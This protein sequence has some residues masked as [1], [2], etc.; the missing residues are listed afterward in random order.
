M[1]QILFYLLCLAF[2]AKSLAQSSRWLT[3]VNE[4]QE[5]PVALGGSLMGATIYPG[6]RLLAEYPLKVVERRSGRV[7]A[8]G[9]L[10][11]YRQKR[12][13][14]ALNFSLNTYYQKGFHTNLYALVEYQ[15]RWLNRRGCFFEL[16]PLGLG[17]SYTF[18][19]AP[20]FTTNSQGQVRQIPLAG[21]PYLVGSMSLG[22]GKDYRYA[23]KIKPFLW[24]ARTGLH[25]FY[26]YSRL[27]FPRP[28]LEL[29]AAYY[30]QGLK[31]RPR[32]KIIEDKR[33]P[34]PKTGY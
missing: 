30:W 5:R 18:L 23:K 7:K 15:F 25:V 32:C 10:I 6:F 4:R 1:K 17:L 33:N 22:W 14:Q 11:R 13:Q 31:A 28:I 34:F 21:H 2:S 20:T 24:Y 8:G 12:H 9:N 26:P 29:G 16:S 3:T 19:D 27:A